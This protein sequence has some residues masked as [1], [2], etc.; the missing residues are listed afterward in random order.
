MLGK[1]RLYGV[2]KPNRSN[3][4]HW[5]TNYKN[6]KSNFYYQSNQ[7]PENLDHT[8]DVIFNKAHVKSANL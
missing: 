4:L 8:V 3:T 2:R 7:V 6:Y 1:K 5:T